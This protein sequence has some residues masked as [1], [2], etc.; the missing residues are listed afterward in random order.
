MRVCG[1]LYYNKK[2]DKWII[3]K[4]PPHVCIKL[5]SIFKKIPKTGT[6]PFYFDNT[7]SECCD[8]DWFISRYTME[9][10]NEDRKY[11]T[12]MVK[13][14]HEDQAYIGSILSPNYIPP[15][16]V[17]LKEGQKI[18]PYQAQAGDI[19]HA[20]SSILLGD[21]VGLGKTYSGL[22]FLLKKGVLPAAIVTQTH[23][24]KQ[25]HE[26]NE[27]F[28]NLKTHM[29]TKT[30]PYDLPK[31][32]VYIFKYT[33]LAGWVDFFET[34]FF[35]AVVYDE[36]Q[37]LRRGTESNKGQGALILS[38]NA[39][40]RM[41]LTA[42]PIYN[43]GNEIW[44][45][46]HY[47]DPDVLGD[48]RSF[49]IEWVKDN[50]K[51]VIDPDALGSYLREQNVFLRRTKSDVGQQMPPINSIVETVETDEKTLK[52][53]NDLAKQLAIKT[54]EGSFTERGQAGR[55]LDLLLRHAT[56][57][58][59]A[60][61][62]AQYVKLLV[63][64]DIP[65]LLLGW[66]RDVYDIWK[67]ELANYRV[68]MYTGSESEKQKRES[69]RLFREGIAQVFIMS[70]RSGAG[71]DGLQ[72]CCSTVVLGELDWSPKVH[73][74]IIGRLYREGQ[75][76]QVTAIHL[77]SD[78]GSDPPM[79]EMLGLKSSQSHG[80]LDPGTVPEFKHSDKSRIQALAEKYVK[81]S[82]KK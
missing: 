71:V 20:R 11:L 42:T 82:L 43:Y 67:R 62:V 10:T 35:K 24:Q 74:Q 69:L 72:H 44:N 55:E 4:C 61:G 45:V 13:N 34:G 2:E 9:M 80:I 60:K 78:D 23:L 64:S 26:K 76:E 1:K 52:S 70:L 8:L 75:K 16:I 6:V 63:E 77:V 59:K 41:G 5:K 37:E 28:T 17:G 65:V 57:V 30:T 73:E 33:Q 53:V 32:D 47:V 15:K 12:K 46:M 40:Y 3:D 14:Y 36:I 22:G 31:A 19:C 56:G 21:V 54:I 58:A 81:K 49:S 39:Q 38:S 25:W 50:G 29:I 66:H 7:N 68:V 27:E 48:Y 51:E 18:R 79:V